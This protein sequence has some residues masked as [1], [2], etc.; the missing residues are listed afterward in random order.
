MANP[1]Q[2]P[3]STFFCPDLIQ[4][5]VN[6]SETDLKSLV[7]LVIVNLVLSF[8]KMGYYKIL[9][10]KASSIVESKDLHMKLEEIK[11]SSHRV[12]FYYGST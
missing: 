12:C 1:S 10:Y 11:Q 7:I 2:P 5:T 4:G 9:G 8:A 3:I 6:A